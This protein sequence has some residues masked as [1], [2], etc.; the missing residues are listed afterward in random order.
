VRTRADGSFGARLRAARNV[1]LRAVLQGTRPVVRTASL[2]V[3]ADLPVTVRR[4]GAGGHHP[5]V[6]VTLLAPPRASIRHR[7]VAFYLASATDTTWHR[8]ATRRW[9]RRKLVKLTATATYPGGRLG[10]ADRVLVC[11]REPRPDPY[12]KPVALDRS[13]GARRLPRTP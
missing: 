9:K 2:T 8:V 13:C 11:T 4:L 6:R 1:R 12:G 3:W 7:R 10:S 5:R